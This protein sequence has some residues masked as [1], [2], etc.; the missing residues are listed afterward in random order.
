MKLYAHHGFTDFV[1]CV[2][3][4]GYVIKEYF[5]NCFLHMSDVTFDL[6]NNNVEVH[7]AQASRGG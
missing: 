6:A 2:G 3:Y 4:K 7:H 5:A 1:V